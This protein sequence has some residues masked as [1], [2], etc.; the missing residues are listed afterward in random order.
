MLQYG[1]SNVSQSIG[2][3][4]CSFVFKPLLIF[5]LF[6]SPQEDVPRQ[7]YYI[8]LYVVHITGAYVLKWVE[9]LPENQPLWLLLGWVYCTLI[10]CLT[11]SSEVGASLCFQHL[12]MADEHQHK[13]VNARLSFIVLMKIASH[14][15]VSNKTCWNKSLSAAQLTCQNILTLPF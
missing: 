14:D 13:F 1:F 5:S 10:E 9:S 7:L 12:G 2:A 4:E 3:L 8:C 15:G 11:L 6:L